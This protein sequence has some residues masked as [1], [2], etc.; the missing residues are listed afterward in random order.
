MAHGNRWIIVVVLLLVVSLVFNLGMLAYAAGASLLL[1]AIARWLTMHWIHSLTATRDCNRLVAEIGDRVAVNV[2]VQ[3]T[4]KLPIPWLLLED[5][6]PRRALAISPPSL[7]VQGTRIKLS[8]LRGRD[9]K[10][11][12]YQMDCNRRGYFQIGPLVLETGDLFGLF[13]RYRVG[14]EPVF[15]LVYPKVTPLE[16]FDLASRRPIGEVRMT[17]RLYEDPTRI[18][19]VRQYEPGD[20]L[21]RVNW[22][23]TARTGMLQ[24]KVYEPSSVA[25]ATLL[26][27]FHTAEH[28][29]AHEPYRSELAVSAA[30]SIA[31]ALYEVG[32]Q[33]GLITNARDAA[34]RVRHEGWRGDMRTRQAA[35][36]SA[37]ML[38]TSDRLRPIVLPAERGP[39]QLRRV[40]ETLARVELTDGLDLAQLVSETT[41]RM[42]RDATVVAILPRV[43]VETAIVLGLLKKRGFA[44]SAI[45][46]TFDPNDF[47]A[48]SGPLLAQGIDTHHLRDETSIPTICRNFVLR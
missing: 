25:G 45:I 6:L 8:M 39:E 46:N 26:L 40:L 1:L 29:S 4:S 41:S 47:A 20:S 35:R 2:K 36:R 16:G 28:D 10:V 21:N 14:A 44:V 23:A 42:P 11:L 38:A 18:A 3:N 7:D 43:Q 37:A 48:A 5:L 27:E 33:F 15:L 17:Y 24:S 19:G 9:A 34:D 30:A 12:A 32:Q 13:R 22:K 31:N